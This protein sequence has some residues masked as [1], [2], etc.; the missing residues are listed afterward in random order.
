MKRSWAFAWIAAL[1]GMISSSASA[2]PPP[3]LPI[4]GYLTDSASAPL[5]GTHQI[6]FR[7][8]D[9]DVAGTALFEETLDVNVADG[10]FTIYLGDTIALDLAIFRDNTDVYL[11]IKVG[12]D[13]EA[14]PRLQLGS[15]A[16]A[17]LAAFCG[18]ADTVGGLAPEDFQSRVVGTC[19][20]GQFMQTIADDGAVT[21][22]APAAETDPTIGNLTM[23]RYCTSTNG[24]T[25]TCDQVL[26]SEGD[27]QVGTLAA[28]GS[29]F[30]NGTLINCTGPTPVITEDDPQV[31]GLT[32]GRWCTT[33][34]SSI[35]CATNPPVLAEVDP[36][37]G[38]LVNGSWCVSN[39]SVVSCNQSFPAEGD[40]QVGALSTSYVPR[41]DGAALNNGKIYD[42]NSNVGINNTA[43]DR[44]LDVVGDV[45]VTG[46]YRYATPKAFSLYLS[47][48]AFTP[49][50][51][52]DLED[53]TKASAG[54][55][56][57]TDTAAGAGGV[58]M[59]ADVNLPDGV[60]MT[61]VSCVYQDE[62]GADAINLS[63]F[64][65]YRRPFASE[66]A[67]QIANTLFSTTAVETNP[68][69]V[70]NMWFDNTFSP[71]GAEV[72]DNSQYDYYIY[73]AWNVSND[74]AGATL[75]FYGCR[76]AYT[77]SA[78]GLP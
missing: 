46:N 66:T 64:I 33:D 3:L 55:G 14:A 73:I 21:C 28:G 65:L 71:A 78:I 63:S 44:Q 75:K 61:G 69:P 39:G 13:A 48:A 38:T 52:A 70:T 53:W 30:S 25:V 8:Y 20:S 24:T 18:D 45:E 37:V 29:C 26:P 47:V 15:T 17:S 54:Y 7:L 4:Q 77:A 32:N 76:V 74:M 1:I 19:A 40:P 59:M 56:Y 12:T 23:N 42:N 72:V 67:T 43:P 2:E 10:F 9:T 41:W 57:M 27:P 50:S 36:K 16:F 11:G 35:N 51:L 31:G 62:S 58:V 34:G 68:S 5:D 60:T 22:A 49:N 6:R